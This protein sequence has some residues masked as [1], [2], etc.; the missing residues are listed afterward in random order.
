MSAPL[1]PQAVIFD[2]DGTL[3]DTADEFVA[4]THQLLVEYDRSPLP[5]DT[6]RRGVS[7]GSA[8]LVSLALGLSPGDA[9]WE[10][11]RNRFLELYNATLG[12]DSRP[13]PGLAELV[14]GLV[15]RGIPWGVVTNKLRAY[16]EP[17]LAM[18]PFA[19]PPGVLVTPDDVR[20]SKPHPEPLF[21]ACRTLGVLP[22]RTVYVGDHKRDIDSGRGAGCQTIAAGYGYIEVGDDPARW[23]ADTLVDS[24]QALADTLWERI[25]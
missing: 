16:A 6:I 19:A 1:R 20:H 24:S 9:G 4:V 25:R 10:T 3:I 23:G 5:V 15:A 11:A 13:Y 8:G 18:M 14:E 17:L 7:N 22:G 2:L 12:D 21:L